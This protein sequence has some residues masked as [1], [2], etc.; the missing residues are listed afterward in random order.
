PF[1]AGQLFFANHAQAQQHAPQRTLTRRWLSPQDDDSIPRDAEQRAAYVEM[2]LDAFN[3]VTQCVDFDD[4][5]SAQV[6]W[7]STASKPAIYTDEQ[8]ET[9]CWQLVS[10]AETLHT[11]GPAS[12]NMFDETKLGYAYTCRK[13]TFV[14]RI[15]YIC[16]V[17]RLSKARCERLLKFE[18]LMI[19]V[20]CPTQLIAQ[21]HRNKRQNALRQTYLVAGR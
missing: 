15:K 10:L 16:A 6:P 12:L 5:K 9:I 7:R 8:V 20:A 19:L 14:N 13:L 3:D 21:T 2:L 11:R 1:K 17:L 4:A 18:G